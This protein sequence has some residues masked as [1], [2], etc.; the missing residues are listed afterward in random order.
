MRNGNH[1]GA[2]RGLQ[3]KRER[4][5]KASDEYKARFGEQVDEIVGN[6]KQNAE[7]WGKN[8]LVISATLAVS[9]GLFKAF[10]GEKKGE[11]EISP[12]KNLV[13]SNNYPVIV[14]PERESTIVRAIK[15]NIALFLLSELKSQLIKLIEKRSKSAEK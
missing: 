2:P 1:E 3:A 13:K 10:T 6:V 8:L 4:L 7:K 11:K 12:G 14:K 9:Y 5:M 15:E